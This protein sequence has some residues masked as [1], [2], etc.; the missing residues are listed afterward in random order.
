VILGALVM[1]GL[2]ASL[3]FVFRDA[4]VGAPTTT[5][6]LPDAGAARP[7]AGTDAA[8]PAPTWLRIMSGS[9]RTT[10]VARALGPPDGECAAIAPGGKILLELAPGTRIHTDGSPSADLSVVVG[11][12]SAPYRIDVLRERGEER[13]Q[14]G[15][16]V[17]GSV[18]IDVDQFA[19]AE[20]RYVRI[21]NP[22]RRGEVCLDAV[23]IVA[24]QNVI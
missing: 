3:V 2:G 23:A 5:T 9:D 13:T 19:R 1:A 15:A 20:F 22:N 21:K 4:I 24:A 16:D 11:E 8:A 10:D 7:D 18:D 14:V 17:V 6:Q 12:S